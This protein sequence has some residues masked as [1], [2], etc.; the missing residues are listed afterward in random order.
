[1]INVYFDVYIYR[2]ESGIENYG[3]GCLSSDLNRLCIDYYKR[4]YV[5]WIRYVCSINQTDD[6]II[7]IAE[8]QRI[9]L[10]MIN[11]YHCI[12]CGFYQ[13]WYFWHCK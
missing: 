12:V 11:I 9:G 6:I 8:L 7:M 4:A 3:K 5:N 13:H 10:I 1:M 2:N